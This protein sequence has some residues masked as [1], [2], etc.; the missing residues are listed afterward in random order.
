MRAPQGDRSR[1]DYNKIS[2]WLLQS[3]MVACHYLCLWA[4]NS[5]ITHN[6]GRI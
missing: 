6:Q 2:S 1:E 3:L 5:A 4:T